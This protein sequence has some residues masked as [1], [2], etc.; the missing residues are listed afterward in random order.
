VPGITERVKLMS[1]QGKPNELGSL[2]PDA[3]KAYVQFQG[4]PQVDPT[5]YL[6]NQFIPE[7]NKFDH[8]AITRFAKTF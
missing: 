7:I 8:D 5:K 6:T 3:W 1:P 4:L 2:D